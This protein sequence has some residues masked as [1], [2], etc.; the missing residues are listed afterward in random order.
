M[1]GGLDIEHFI[2][3]FDFNPRV[4]AQVVD[5][6]ISGNCEQPCARRCLARII[7]LGAAPH[8]QHDFLRELFGSVL[9][10]ALAH[11]EGLDA[12]SVV[13]VD[14]CKSLLVAVTTDRH[15]GVAHGLSQ[16]RCRRVLRC[17]SPLALRCIVRSGHCERGLEALVVKGADHS[18]TNASYTAEVVAYWFDGHRSIAF[19]LSP[20]EL[21]E[22][23]PKIVPSSHIAVV[24]AGAGGLAAAWLLSRGHKVTLLDQEDR[25]GGHAHTATLEGHGGQCVDTGFIV[26]NEPCYPNFTAW[27]SHLGVSTEPSDMSFAVSRED[28]GFE[29]AGGPVLGLIAQPS[30][31]LRPRF[32]RMLRDLVRFYREAPDSVDA[33]SAITLGE[34]LDTNGYS[35]DFIDDHLMP[36]ASAVWSSPCET[37]LDYPAAAFIRFCD[38]HGLLKLTR[39]PRWRTVSGGSHR[40]VSAV[41]SALLE[42][43]H[44]VRTGFKVNSVE[45]HSEGVLI[46]SEAGHSVAADAVV[47][48]THADQALGCLDAPDELEQSLLEPFAYE[49]NLAVLH[50]DINHLPRRR[51]AWCS[52]NYVERAN[53]SRTQVSVSYWMNRLQNLPGS[54]PF[55]VTL[56]PD[57]MP[58][59]S[60]VLRTSRYEHPIF[61]VATW[62]AQQRLWELQGRRRT[63]F[64]GSY[65]GAGF[66]EDAVQAGLAAAESIG[67]CQRPWQLDEPSSRIVVPSHIAASVPAFAST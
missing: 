53:T 26:F 16:L 67:N 22:L 61:N 40:Y 56:N 24:G 65:F 14:Q 60:E 25:L 1:L 10:H 43:G 63:W 18:C 3:Q 35:A 12:S 17:S 9:V 46:H 45:R 28:G 36:F 30:V 51:R 32:W 37:M 29:Y 39:R 34:Y 50:T 23:A 21:S 2:V 13:V 4:A 58:S 52:W 27:M 42:A 64:C 49:S 57:E 55:I 38:N 6:A 44:E 11:Q 7:A 8:R 15:Q 41:Q 47:M 31:L 20:S 19:C 59:E 62:Q 66:H 33:D 5:T 54:T 48:A